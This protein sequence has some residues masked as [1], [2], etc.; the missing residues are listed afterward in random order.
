MTLIT[1]RPSSV[2]LAPPF[3]IVRRPAGLRLEGALGDRRWLI[4]RLGE[5]A[6]AL[7][8]EDNPL[9]ALIVR[10]PRDLQLRFDRAMT[11]VAE[12][13]LSLAEATELR[14]TLAALHTV[15]PLLADDR[16]RLDADDAALVGL[17]DQFD[18]T[19]S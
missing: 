9:R 11:L 5:A 13:W 1:A 6:T 17:I 8:D 3:T 14:V 15:L 7:D 18:A 19:L 12:P 4:D 16:D 2:V 10:S